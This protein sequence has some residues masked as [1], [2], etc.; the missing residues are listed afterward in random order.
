MLTDKE[1]KVLKV[2]SSDEFPVL[3]PMFELID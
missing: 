1:I 3:L 2:S